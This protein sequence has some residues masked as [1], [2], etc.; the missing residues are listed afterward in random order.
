MQATPL[1]QLSGAPLGTG[2]ESVVRFEPF[3]FSIRG[4][5]LEALLHPPTVIQKLLLMQLTPDKASDD[6]PAWFGDGT[7]D[8]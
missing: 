3:H 4:F 6:A 5:P 7:I 2:A 8:H 1:S